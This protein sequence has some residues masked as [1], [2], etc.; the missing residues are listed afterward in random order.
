[1]ACLGLRM[2]LQARLASKSTL[3]I[4]RTNRTLIMQARKL[5]VAKKENST[6]ACSRFDSRLVPHPDHTNELLL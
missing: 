3:L 6:R 1:M 2:C 4:F 5:E